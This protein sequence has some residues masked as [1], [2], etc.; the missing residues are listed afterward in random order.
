[1][2]SNDDP[3]TLV[4]II[5]ASIC[6]V[7]VIIAIIVFL[8]FTNQ[9][10][11]RDRIRRRISRSERKLKD[12]ITNSNDEIRNDFDGDITTPMANELQPITKKE[13][14]RINLDDIKN[15]RYNSNSEV[16]S[17]GNPSV[18]TTDHTIGNS[19]TFSAIATGVTQKTMEEQVMVDYA[20][21]KHTNNDIKI[22]DINV[23]VDVGQ[24]N[25]TTELAIINEPLTNIGGNVRKSTIKDVVKIVDKSNTKTHEFK[26]NDLN[27]IEL[28]DESKIQQVWRAQWDSN[29]VLVKIFKNNKGTKIYYNENNKNNSINPEL[30][31]RINSSIDVSSKIPHHPN[32][33][34]TI[35][36]CLSPLSLI[37]EYCHGG[38]LQ[39]YIYNNNSVYKY[40]ILVLYY[41]VISQKYIL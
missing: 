32:V 23:S 26:E 20:M 29:D 25:K 11:F 39:D 16:E 14:L 35:G 30:I 10:C 24:G 38:N 3:L 28:L 4:L 31:Q 13:D 22:K 6:V 15:R 2:S 21:I 7:I 5:V 8:Y 33:V 37:E 18:T 36:Y 34:R 12:Q 1:M 9:C 40:I 27:L 19:E 41:Y 17:F